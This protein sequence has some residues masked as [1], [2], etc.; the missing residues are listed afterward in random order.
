VIGQNVLR[1]ILDNSLEIRYPEAAR[2]LS[3]LS[4]QYLDQHIPDRETLMREVKA[5]GT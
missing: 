4:R 1:H 2:M 5:R 3:V